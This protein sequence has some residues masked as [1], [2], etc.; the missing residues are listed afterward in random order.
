MDIKLVCFDFDGV[1]TNGHIYF[2]NNVVN[3]YYNIKDGMG[4]KILKDNNIKIG[5]ITGFKNKDYLINDNNIYSLLEHLKFDYFKLGVDNKLT[6]IDEWIKELNINYTNVAYIGDDINDIEILEKVIYSACPNDAVKECKNVVNYVCNNKGGDGCVREFIE[7]ILKLKKNKYEKIIHEIK[8]ESNFQLNNLNINEIENF[9][10]LIYEKYKINKT[11]YCTGVGKS[12]NIAIHCSNLL[13]S[14]GLKSYYLNCLNSIHGDIGTIEKDDII[15]IFS[16]SGNTNELINIINA[17]KLHNPYLISI[18]CN[19][20]GI[21]NKLCDKSIVLPLNNEL[22]FNENINTIPT[23]SYMVTLFFINILTMML[24][25][26]IQLK[27]DKYKLN[28]PGGNIGINLMTIDNV[29]IIDFPKI[30]LHNNVH[31]SEIL[32]EMTKYSIGCCFFVNKN[33]ELIG[34]LTDGDIRRIL[35]Q[36]KYMDIIT[37]ENI[38]TSFYYETDKNK[39]VCEIINIK[40][41]KYIPVLE[42]NKLIGIIKS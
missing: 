26:K 20:N 36:N 22:K 19:D 41:Y 21:L 38:N 13:K 5:L 8:T 34:L 17:I 4:L 31:L 9:V 35:C 11:I 39:I 1:F 10:D 6:V 30:L 25:D 16:K 42:N 18:S 32:L 23:N 15:L 14:I 40:K 27:Y 3:K 37:K 7:N 28:H 33:D 29:M 2:S 24:C 12:E